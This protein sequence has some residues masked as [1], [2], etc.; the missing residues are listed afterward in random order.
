MSDKVKKSKDKQITHVARLA[1]QMWN[2]GLFV[3][4]WVFY[5]NNIVF[6]NPKGYNY[7]S[8][9]Y[10]AIM[11]LVFFIIYR[12]ICSVYKAFR[13]ASTSLFDIVFAHFVSFGI[14]DLFS[15]LEG[16]LIAHRYINILPGVG[17]VVAQLVGTMLIAHKTKHMLMERMIPNDTLIVYGSL[18]NKKGVDSFISRLMKKYEHLYKVSTI[19]NENEELHSLSEEIQ[20]HETIILLGVAP[21]IR[22]ELIKICAEHNKEFLYDPRIEDIICEGCTERYLLDTPLMK[23]DFPYQNTMR[24]GVKRFWDIFLSILFLIILS[25]FMIIIAVTIKME[26]GGTVFYKQKRCTKDGKV[27]E[28]LKFRSMVEN[29]EA[30]GAVPATDGDPRITKVGKVIRATRFDEIPQLLNILKGDM[31][32]VGPR[33]E[34][35]EH[36]DL[37]SK[38]MPEFKYRLKVRGGLTGY[39]QV[40]GKYN[41]TPY[42]KLRLDLIYIENQS[43]L[44][45]FKI[46][47]LTIRTIFQ[48]E[49]TE[50]FDEKESA[51]INLV[52]QTK[53]RD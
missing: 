9:L 42:D 11:I 31:S 33:P 4:V 24:A 43:F 41:T 3:L 21:T 18:I 50:G 36:M 28:I 38:E 39:A 5:Y 19:S 12:S 1:L 30:F 14:S 15:Y 16:C 6:W 40:Y 7:R 47:L 27:F 2:I 25:P 8:P 34:R 35:V 48:K 17:I 45:D 10:A 32:F 29:A 49:A 52:M 22:K 51:E 46:L 53:M 37:Y 13:F 23:Y 44:M 26:D 20:Q